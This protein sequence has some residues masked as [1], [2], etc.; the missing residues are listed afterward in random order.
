MAIREVRELGDDILRKKSKPID[1]IDDKIKTLAA[2]M[3]ET[4]RKNDGV[5]IAAVQVGILKRLI[6][7]ELEDVTNEPLIL[8]NPVIKKQKGENIAE[9]GCLSLPKKYAQVVRPKEI[10]I[11]A[12]DLDGKKIEMKA[13]D[14]LAVVIC[15]EID[16]LEGILFIDKMEEG[17]LTVDE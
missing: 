9:E 17:T 4:M 5:G 14:L 8:I 1:K 16:H 15:H 2:D 7:I 13:K 11:E 10:E 12:L 3:I 6:V